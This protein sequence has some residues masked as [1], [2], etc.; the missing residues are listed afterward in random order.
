MANTKNWT[1]KGHNWI[2]SS[3]PSCCVSESFTRVTLL[4]DAEYAKKDK[5]CKKHYR[6]LKES[7]KRLVKMKFKNVK[8]KA[9]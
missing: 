7:D 2:C 1:Y 5:D 9:Y 8:P 4:T 3:K 6:R